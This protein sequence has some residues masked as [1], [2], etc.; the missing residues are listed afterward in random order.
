MSA[1]GLLVIAAEFRGSQRALHFQHLKNATAPADGRPHLDD[2]LG[3]WPRRYEA[4]RCGQD[5]RSQA[6]SAARRRRAAAAGF[7]RGRCGTAAPRRAPAI[8]ASASASPAADA[9]AAIAA[10][11]RA[12]PQEP[13]RR[14]PSLQPERG[15]MTSLRH[16]LARFLRYYDSRRC[17]PIAVIASRSRELAARAQARADDMI[18][19]T[20]RAARPFYRATILYLHGRA[21]GDMVPHT[22]SRGLPVRRCAQRVVARY[23]RRS[24]SL[25][26]SVA[27]RATIAGLRVL[28]ALS[29]RPDL[30]RAPRSRH[31]APGRVVVSPLSRRG[32]DQSI[33]ARLP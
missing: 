8:R 31:P 9:A 29:A 21:C 17:S 24:A 27:R 11:A 25:T 23:S 12:P 2:N 7:S 15:S 10:Q 28:K 16:R 3:H 32:V 18:D 6:S 19:A 30:W 20:G 14:A 5:P 4:G 22:C 33:W 13:R 1:S 26:G